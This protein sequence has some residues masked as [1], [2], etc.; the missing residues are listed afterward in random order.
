MADNPIKLVNENGTIIGI[1]PNTGDKIPVEFE[2]LGTNGLNNTQF[3]DPSD[4]LSTVNTYLSSAGTVV[5]LPGKHEYNDIVEIA[6]DNVTVIISEGATV[7][8]P[9]SATPSGF[10]LNGNSPNPVILSDG[11]DNIRIVNCGQIDANYT[12]TST[13][14]GHPGI[15]LYNGVNC[16]YYG[17]GGIIYDAFPGIW[18]VDCER[19]EL[20]NVQKIGEPT[21][22]AAVGVEGC[23]S[24]V[25]DGVYAEKSNEVVDLN[26]TNKNIY[27]NN[28]VGKEITL[29]DDEL[30]DINNSV[31]CV[32]EG[33]RTDGT[34]PESLITV[35]D[36]SG[37]RFT[38]KA[39]YDTSE[40]ITVSDVQGVSKGNCIT[41]RA[42]TS[43]SSVEVIDFDVESTNGEGVRIFPEADN[44][45][46]NVTL[47]GHAESSS[48]AGSA[49]RGLNIGDANYQCDGLHLCVSATSSDGNG[50]AITG[51][52]NIR[53]SIRTYNTAAGGLI[54]VSD[55]TNTVVNNVQLDVSVSGSSGPG[56]VGV[57]SGPKS[58]CHISGYAVGNSGDDMKLEGFKD[59]ILTVTHDTLNRSTSIRTLVNG[60]GTNSGDP[61]STGEWS[62]NGFEG[63]QVLDTAN[64]N[65]Y[66]Y[67][68]G[69]WVAM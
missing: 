48:T 52:E 2:S 9:D 58:N 55:G 21:S 46:S 26:H 62:G 66:A 16:N 18:W 64:G 47:R 28:V 31:G 4:T 17:M 22:G 14:D 67:V 15:F 19:S 44:S 6:S 8:Y 63:A 7:G 23:V 69:S 33:V 57:L 39:T 11:N 12:G 45:I 65:N 32:V 50:V 61:N 41:I 49:H 59:S 24:C 25:I 29:G 68:N 56:I 34:N 3:V 1:D 20:Q 60:W 36:R 51:F 43:V 38:Q 30:V 13:G 53:G 27:V 37:A 35:N 5:F 42:S 54:F 10:S 40:N